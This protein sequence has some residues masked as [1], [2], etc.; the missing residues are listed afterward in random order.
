MYL[1]IHAFH[2]FQYTVVHVNQSLDGVWIDNYILVLEHCVSRL[3]GGVEPGW[4]VA[5]H[6]AYCCSA[7]KG[8]TWAHARTEGETTD[9][10]AISL[11][12]ATPEAVQFALPCQSHPT[13][14]SY[15]LPL[16]FTISVLS[17]FASRGAL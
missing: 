2:D 8:P 11:G 17:C 4:A 7:G 5:A 12:Y 3:N 16:L 13:S 14:I 9:A 10:I 15:L 6:L 1:Q